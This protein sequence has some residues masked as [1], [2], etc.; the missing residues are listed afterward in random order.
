MAIVVREV[1]SIT[2]ILFEND[3]YGYAVKNALGPLIS[4]GE[5]EFYRRVHIIKYIICVRQGG[6]PESSRHQSNLSIGRSLSGLSFLF[7]LTFLMLTTPAV[8]RVY[9]HRDILIRSQYH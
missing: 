9:Y 5:S 3:E 7:F 2:T 8:C 4:A 1:E 6:Y